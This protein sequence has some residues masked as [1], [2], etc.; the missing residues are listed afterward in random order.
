MPPEPAGPQPEPHFPKWRLALLV[1]G[2]AAVA[3]GYL[4]AVSA[5]RANQVPSIV[6]PEPVSGG[7]ALVLVPRQM[8]AEADILEANLLL[9]PSLE[10]VDRRDR[11]I[12][13]IEVDV[14][15]AISRGTIVY[16]AGSLPAPQPIELAVTGEVAQYPFDRYAIDTTVQVLTTDG[17]T[18]PVVAESYFR[19]PG[20]VFTPAADTTLAPEGDLSLYGEIQRDPTVKAIAALLLALMVVLAAIAVAF[21]AATATRRVRLEVP[22]ASF[23]ALLLFALLPIRTYFPGDPPIG[24]WM[25]ILVF[26]WVEAVLMLSVA[27]IATF[28]IVRGVKEA[29]ERRAAARSRPVEGGD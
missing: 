9:V 11:L 22:V 19:V 27:L 13:N 24:S 29:R 7:V 18:V 4:S 3:I 23:T 12:Q 6:R 2:L 26:F 1:L 16:P 17:G 14:G 28:I 15:A 10:L 20:W 21:V 5:F 8:D 25:D